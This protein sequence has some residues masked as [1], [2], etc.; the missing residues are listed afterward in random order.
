MSVGAPGV[1]ANDA[2][3]EGDKLTAK[4]VST[5][6]HGT[7]VLS[8]DGAFIYI[9]DGSEITGD[10]FT[11][12]ANDGAMDSN[13]VTVTIPIQTDRELVATGDSYTVARGDTLNVKAPG[14]LANDTNDGQSPLSAVLVTN[15]RHGSLVLS[16]DGSFVYTHDGSPTN[17]DSFTYK[18]NDGNLDSNVATVFIAITPTLIIGD[19]N[20]DGRV[21]AIDLLLVTAA[22]G[23]VG[24]T[25]TDV[26]GNGIVDLPDL[27][28]V[29]LYFDR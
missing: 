17:S 21:D 19:V 20:K 6:K 29:G 25:A 24:N 1:L 8:G 28:L 12:K 2:D 16:G 13:V 26:D 18:A 22:L 4:L 11:Y 27:V 7:L 3:P 9:H 15:V 10:E 5:V 14:V 23:F